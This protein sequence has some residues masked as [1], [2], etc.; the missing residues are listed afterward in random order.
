MG[1]LRYEFVIIGGGRGQLGG[2]V[3][4]DADKPLASGTLEVSATPTAAGAQPVV[5]ALGR[6]DVFVRLS[7]IDVAV[8]ADFAAVPDPTVEPR[9][10]LRPG[11][12]RLLRVM[13]GERLSAIVAADVPV[14][15]PR[16]PVAQSFVP[17]P[18]F[19]AADA[20]GAGGANATIVQVLPSS[21]MRSFLA[22]D[23]NGAADVELWF[24]ARPLAS[25]VG[26]GLRQGKVLQA[27]GGGLLRDVRVETGAVY[28]TA[29]AATG[30]C[31]VEG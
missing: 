17:V 24:G 22:I 27:N 25:A 3:A 29:A 6:A 10:L 14:A 21:A 9:I 28:A 2:M 4:A 13:S 7:G 15:L 31:V 20:S 11:D 30:L 16:L 23:N 19:N 18:A 1:K 8:Y 5:P 26:Q 12:S